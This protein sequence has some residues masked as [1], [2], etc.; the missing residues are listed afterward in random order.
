MPSPRTF[1]PKC[2]TTDCKTP[3]AK[4]ESVIVDGARKRGFRCRNCR[5]ALPVK[6]KGAF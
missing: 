1:R 6:G 4:V 2:G 3:Y 5:A